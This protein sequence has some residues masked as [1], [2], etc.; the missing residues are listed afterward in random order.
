MLPIR[1]YDMPGI[2]E[3][4]CVRQ[5]ELEMILNGELKQGLEVCINVLCIY[6]YKRIMFPTQSTN[7][8]DP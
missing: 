2:C 1:F 7:V 3:E 5:N 4:N 8:R 6:I